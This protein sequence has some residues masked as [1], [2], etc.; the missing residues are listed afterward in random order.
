[1]YLLCIFLYIL[2]FLCFT[3]CIKRKQ[4]VSK[5][6][7]FFIPHINKEGLYNIMD[8]KII[9][10]NKNKRFHRN[11]VCSNRLSEFIDRDININNKMKNIKELKKKH[12]DNNILIK[13]DIFSNIIEKKN[14]SNLFF[15]K[16]C[17][18]INME[19][20]ET[21]KDLEELKI[22]KRLKNN[23][24]DNNN[25]NNNNMYDNKSNNIH[26]NNNNN[27]DNLI[28]CIKKNQDVL[29]LVEGY[30]LLTLKNKYMFSFLKK[31]KKIIF[32]VSSGVD[33]LCLLYSF[34][35]VIYKI[36]ISMIYKNKSYF[37]FMNKINSVYSFT[38]EDI[39]DIIKEYRYENN[40]SFFLSILSKIIVI[41]CHHNTR[42]E[43]TSEMYFLK[44][45]CK[46]FGI[47]FKSKKL[48]EKSIQKLNVINL[49][50][51]K[52][53]YESNVNKKININMMKNKK[54]FL[55]LARTWRRNIYVHLS[56]DILKR[57][58]NNNIYH[59]NKM[60]DSHNNNN[61]NDN[62]NTSMKDP[63]NMLDAYTYEKYIYDINN[64]IKIT[65]KKCITNVLIKKESFSKEYSNDSIMRKKKKEGLLFNN[66]MNLQ[67]NNI[68][69]I[70][71]TCSN[72]IYNMKYTNV[73]LNKYCILKKKIK[74]IVFLGHHQNDNN[75]T[76]LLQ[77]FRGV[78][79]K[80]LRGIKFL[81]Y[82]KNCL[83]YRPFIKLNKL[84]L[85]RYMQLINKTWNFDSSNN[86]MSISRNFI[87][88]VVIPNITHMLKDK[89]YKNRENHNIDKEINEKNDKHMLDD[90]VCVDYHDETPLHNKKEMNKY[91][92]VEISKNNIVNKNNELKN[93]HVYVNT[94]LDRRLKNVLRQTTNLEN[95]LNYYDNM[96]FTYLKKKYYKRCMSTTKKITH[97]EETYTNVHDTHNGNIK[98]KRNITKIHKSYNTYKNSDINLIN[99]NVHLKKNIKC[100]NYQDAHN[101]FMNEYFKMQNNLYNIFFPRYNMETLI[102]INKK[103][104]EKNIYLKIFNFFELL[105]LPSKL[106]RLEILYNIIRK[107]VKVNI[108]YAKI[109]RIYEQMIAYINEYIKR[110]KTKYGTTQS[111]HQSHIFNDD[112]TMFDNKMRVQNKSKKENKILNVKIKDLFGDTKIEEVNFVVINI[113]KSKSILLQNNL[114]RIIERDMIEDITKGR[115][116][117]HMDDNKRDDNKRDD[118]K[119]DDNKR[120]DNKR[121]DNKRDDNKRDDNKRDDNKRDDNKRDDNK[122]DDNKRDDNKRDDKKDTHIQHDK[123]ITSQTFFP[124]NKITIANEKCIKNDEYIDNS[125][126]CFKEKSANI[127]VHNNISTEVSRLKKYD[128]TKK[129]D[130]KNIFLLIKKRKKKK[131]EKFHIHI[132]YIKKNDYVYL[133]KKKISVNKFL[134]LHKIPYIYQTAL[135]VIEIINFNNNHILFFYLFPE[136]KSPYFTLR[137]K[138]FPQKYMN[139]HFVYSIKF[140]GIRD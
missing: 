59:N 47:H 135:P 8:K 39:I 25:N 107:Y 119:R 66:I 63:L 10:V 117:L 22:N 128:I 30:W 73:F 15:K 136:V 26:N 75:E 69:I 32:S 51:K 1:M 71:N 33:S 37:G 45:I 120:D 31:K 84:H 123:D 52:K 85:Y 125:L 61:N 106:I 102:K 38:H 23:N 53:N 43:C 29:Q 86:N 95:Y 6:W 132:R 17:S 104:Y 116:R 78:F 2:S 70:N 113:T 90:N 56:N 129:N 72:N 88:N 44:N 133:E 68:K 124:H 99:R 20:D 76:V 139:T 101:I 27:S 115:K 42:K 62:N 96:F 122:R 98:N 97:E 35:F 12:I 130:K 57:D 112:D 49:K 89:S 11:V 105:L 9:R 28:K 36:L 40:V 13:A 14:N 46:K 55:L 67:N 4:N 19:Y 94:S 87:R 121:D 81:T 138:T 100:Y 65:N 93:Q 140:K 92:H 137:E 77:F 134:T 58:M 118:N 54:N 16:F 111:F 64:Y 21:T 126:V 60:K 34:I 131:K 7:Q 110:D 82:Y 108:K 127:F 50:T 80:N 48:T 74:S 41:Y 24:N 18:F 114:F 109:E 83:L 3:I 103:L 91:D 79:L 5:R